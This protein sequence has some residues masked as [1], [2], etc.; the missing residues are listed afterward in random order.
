MGYTLGLFGGEGKLEE[1][2]GGVGEE[3]RMMKGKKRRR[4]SFASQ[5][6]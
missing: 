3:R 5:Q 6:F 2:A 4:G 1:I